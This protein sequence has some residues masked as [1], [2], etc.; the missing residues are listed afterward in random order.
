MMSQFMNTHVFKR[1]Y[2]KE[3]EDRLALIH[4]TETRR[5]NTVTRPGEDPSKQIVRDLETL[6][7]GITV[8]QI[9]K[10]GHHMRKKHRSK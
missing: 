4:D 7:A 2:V 5:R 8:W 3:E 9:P 10:R 1:A 6:A